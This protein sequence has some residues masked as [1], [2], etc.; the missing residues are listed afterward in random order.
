MTEREQG[1]SLTS[2]GSGG[3][4]EGRSRPPVEQG[5]QCGAPY[6]VPAKSA[7]KINKPERK[8]GIN[9]IFVP[10]EHISSQEHKKV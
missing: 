8:V 9:M 1:S 3:R 7:L 4:G 2:K 6:Q 5:A 10:A